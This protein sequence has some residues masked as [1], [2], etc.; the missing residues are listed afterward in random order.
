MTNDEKREQKAMLML[1]HHEA[2][3]VLARATCK[4]NEL[5]RQ[6]KALGLEAS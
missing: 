5:A 3:Q 4:V 2:V 6:K 1:E